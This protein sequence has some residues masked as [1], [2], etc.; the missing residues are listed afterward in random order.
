MDAPEI[1][2]T[3]YTTIPTYYSDEINSTLYTTIPTYN[4][5]ENRDELPNENADVSL[6]STAHAIYEFVLCIEPGLGTV[7]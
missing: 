2:S 5:E 6:Q 3:F 7:V 4:S 1:G